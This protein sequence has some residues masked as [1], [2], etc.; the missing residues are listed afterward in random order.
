MAKIF[1]TDQEIV[2]MV[3]KAFDDAELTNYGLNLKVLSLSKAKDVIK[4]NKA[5]ATTEFLAKKD[6]MITVFIYEAAFDRLDLDS[7]KMLI[8]MAI[9]NVSVNL[10]TFCCQQNVKGKI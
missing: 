9:S 4:V 10:E 1:E 3:N 6:S 7:K 2:E 8:D 5:S